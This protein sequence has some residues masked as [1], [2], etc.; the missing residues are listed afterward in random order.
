MNALTL[1]DDIIHTLGVSARRSRVL[2]LGCGVAA[3]A[4]VISLCG[5]V[6]WVGLIVP[7]I[8]RRLFSVNTRTSLPGSMVI[9]ALFLV[10]C[11]DI[12][13]VLIASEI[14]LGVITSFV[15]AVAFLLLMILRKE[16]PAV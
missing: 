9:G 12:G 13:R 16:R 15:G 10:L 7:H 5:I 6:G 11:D 14:P 1:R 3:A 4:S 2:L 8:S